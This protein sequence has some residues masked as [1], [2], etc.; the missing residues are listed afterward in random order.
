MPIS[1]IPLIFVPHRISMI[2]L[3][4]IAT[5]RIAVGIV[6]ACI[7]AVRGIKGKMTPHI[8]IKEEK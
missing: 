2:I 7:L 6:A 5:A 3:T 8:A 1:L 4:T